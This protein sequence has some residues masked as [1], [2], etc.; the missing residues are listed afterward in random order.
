MAEA[1]NKGG[2]PRKDIDL[3]TFKKACFLQCPLTEIAYLLDCSEDTVERWCKR[4][5]KMG[6]A[7]AYK[8]YSAGGKMSLRHYQF[9][10][11]EKNAAMAIFLGKVVLGQ[12]ENPEPEIDVTSVR[13]VLI[14]VRRTAEAESSTEAERENRDK[15]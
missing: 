7:D 6:F 14:S 1:K 2:R 13:E 15:S 4:E 9:R 3:K 10:L 8:K 5:L 12:Q 11:A